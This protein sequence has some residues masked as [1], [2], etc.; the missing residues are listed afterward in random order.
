MPPCDTPSG[1]TEEVQAHLGLNR[2][3]GAHAHEVDVDQRAL[4][5]VALD[6]A[7]E[8]ELVPAVDLER[9][10]R[11]GAGARGEDVA[12]LVRRHGDRDRSRRRGRRR[13]RAG[14]PHGAAARP[15]GSPSRSGARR[16]AW[17]RAWQQILVQKAERQILPNSAAAAVGRPGGPSDVVAA[18]ELADRAVLEHGLDRVGEE[19][20]DRE[21]PQVVEV[22]VVGDRA[23]CW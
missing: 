2:L 6:L 20:G 4:H 11:V 10:Q 21:H 15:G 5:R 16:Q 8:R 7:G 13:R 12:E 9:D 23:R 1:C 17:Y 14:G 3:V 22:L 19:R 18:E